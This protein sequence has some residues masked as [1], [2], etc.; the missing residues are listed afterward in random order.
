MV[1][2]PLF[3]WLY[4]SLVVQDSSINSMIKQIV[5]NL[6]MPL[7]IKKGRRHIESS[8]SLHL[9]L[10]IYMM[11]VSQRVLLFNLPLFTTSF[12]WGSLVQEPFGL[13]LGLPGVTVTQKSRVACW[14]VAKYK[15]SRAIGA[16]WSPS[17]QSENHLKQIWKVKKVGCLGL[18]HWIYLHTQDAIVAKSSF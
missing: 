9:P 7:G 18:I 14:K 11:L 10:S 5:Q 16:Y 4:T 8:I 15:G 3:T 17:C 1:N 2:M 12:L 6:W 13:V